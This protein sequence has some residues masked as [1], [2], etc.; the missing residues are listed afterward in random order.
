MTAKFDQNKV[1]IIALDGCRADYFLEPVKDQNIDYIYKSL[2]HN[3]LWEK[4]DKATIDQETYFKINAWLKEKNI[5]KTVTPGGSAANTLTSVLRA[6]KGTA[7]SAEVTFICTIGDR[8]N[9]EFIRGKLGEYDGVNIVPV[10]GADEQAKVITP[11]SYIFIDVEDGIA[12]KFIAKNS[13]YGNKEL[14]TA[15]HVKEIF[16]AKKFDIAYLYG[17]TKFDIEVVKAF[18][19]EALKQKAKIFFPLPSELPNNEIREF[20]LDIIDNHADLIF[21]NMDELCNL[22]SLDRKLEADRKKAVK[23]LEKKLQK[24]KCCA[25]ITN[26]T[27]GSIAITPDGLATRPVWEKL[28]EIKDPTGAGDAFNAGVITALL[29]GGTTEE[30]QSLGALNANRTLQQLGAQLPGNVPVVLRKQIL[31]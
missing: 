30:A 18:K 6:L 23:M 24:R 5:E 9:G 2:H 1:N 25:F 22:F 15:K 28:L 21:G 14:I 26:S 12:E 7:K 4:G 10:L 27:N 8:T 16:A 19:T 13:G 29:L 31:G 3:K 17:L 20:A 11:V